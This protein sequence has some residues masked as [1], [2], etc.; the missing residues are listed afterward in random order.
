MG[1]GLG[2]GGRGRTVGGD[3]EEVE[4]LGEVLLLPAHLVRD[5]D[6]DGVRVRVGFRVRV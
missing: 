5:R 4:V 3:R 1:L 6:K 2:V